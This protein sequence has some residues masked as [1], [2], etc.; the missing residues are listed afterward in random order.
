MGDG[1]QA[2]RPKD[3]RGHRI[4]RPKAVALHQHDQRR[5]TSSP[6][7]AAPTVGRLD[8]AAVRVV[9]HA[10]PVHTQREGTPAGK[11][12]VEEL[13]DRLGAL[14]A[15]VV[16]QCPEPVR[17]GLDGPRAPRCIGGCLHR[18]EKREHERAPRH[19]STTPRVDHV[20]VIGPSRDVLEVVVRAEPVALT[21]ALRTVLGFVTR[22][23]QGGARSPLVLFRMPVPT[24]PPCYVRNPRT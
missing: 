11:P 15:L 8:H 5:C 6:R 22:R 7:R 20:P 24:G 2:D 21:Q 19:P 3:A 18:G 17:E 16:H 14:W 4:H 9:R 13:H 10:G 23:N 1:I 12:R